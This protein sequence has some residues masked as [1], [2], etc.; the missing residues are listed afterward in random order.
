MWAEAPGM[1]LTWGQGGGSLQACSGG[2]T[3]NK[4]QSMANPTLS[5]VLL[6]HECWDVGGQPMWLPS[7]ALS[8]VLRPAQNPWRRRRPA[9]APRRG[10]GG[11]RLFQ[12]EGSAKGT[13]RNAAPSPAGRPPGRPARRRTHTSTLLKT[14]ACSWS[15][16]AHR[17]H[18][19]L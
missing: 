3:L 13:G 9:P 12:E 4:S 15:H 17:Y 10:R 2:A 5:G 1:G 7:V 14:S 19:D 16:T 18:H 8:L 11:S 6:G